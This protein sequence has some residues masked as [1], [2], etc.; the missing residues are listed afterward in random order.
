MVSEFKKQQILS[1]CLSRSQIAEHAQTHKFS[2]AP[3][4]LHGGQ[5]TENTRR[6]R[7]SYPLQQFRERFSARSMNRFNCLLGQRPCI[8]VNDDNG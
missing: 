1:L 6:S 4:P 7:L 8:V 5:K 2:P 3:I